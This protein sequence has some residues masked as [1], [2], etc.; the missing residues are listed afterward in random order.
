MLGKGWFPAQLG[1]LDRYYRQL[2]ERLPEAH[3]IVIGPAEDAS[4]RVTAVSEQSAPLPIRLLAFT[5]AARRE[6]RR[7]DIIDAHFALYALLPLFVGG[8]RH[9]PLL[10]H[11]HGP[12]ADENVSIGDTSRWRLRARR[13]LERIVYSRAQVVI[14]LTGAFRRV[15]VE[16]YGVSPWK[17]TVLAP[18]VDLE[19]FSAGDRSEARARFGLGPD[20]FVA[21]CAR[22]LVPRMGIDVLIEAWEEAVSRDPRARLLIAGDGALRGELERETA[23]R[24]LSDSVTLL[25]RITDEQLL[26]LYRAA[27]VN[28]VPSISFEGFGLVVLEA[29]ACGTPSIVTRAG[30]LPEAIVGLGEDLTVAAGDA[31]ALA[32]RLLRAQDGDLPSREHTRSWADTHN[33]AT[34]A[35]GH[36]EL[37][38]RVLSEREGRSRKLRVV[39][40]DHVARLSGGELALLRLVAALS[41]VEAHVI[42]A[43]EGPLVDR[44]LQAGISV[45]VLPLPERTRDLRKDSVRIGRLALRS[46]YDTIT[47]SLRLARRLR[48]LRPDVVHTNS[49]KAG[50]YGSIAA[51]MARLP[52]VWHVRDRLEPDYLPMPAVNLVRSLARYLPDV[53]VC[54]S[55]ATKR[56][57]RPN[58]RALV[59]SMVDL[60]AP[61][62]RPH[63]ARGAGPLVVG[64]VG[65]LAP[66]KGQDVF[67]RAFARAFPVGRSQAVIVGAPL[68]GADEVAYADSLSALV[69]EL[70]IASRVEFRGHRDDITQELR[71][72][73]ILVH[74]STTPEPFGQVVIEGMSAALP[75][76]ASR[77]GGPE[78]IIT[79]GVDGL[80]HPPGD[81]AEL[82][83]ILSR[84]E[85]E[86]DLRERLGEAAAR[87]A[88]DFAPE[89]IAGKM[90]HAYQLAVRAR[91]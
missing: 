54:N 41:D 66:W 68:F 15:L 36:R 24:S 78:E 32:E 53:L 27:D 40:L 75:V 3:G 16:R 26:A 87:R 55:Q 10:V 39:Y 11:F 51:R 20:A 21:C 22:R 33:W 65:R 19:R 62:S 31:G 46:T 45:E 50:I 86:P 84:L 52:V 61:D 17:T 14:T 42:L 8:L 44:L 77:G 18:G 80:L 81:V 63:S 48:R 9:K 90:M 2:L 34:V 82:A 76:V 83:E 7:A 29:A 1:G 13:R 12:W 67:L 71:R 56:S 47:Y 57:L 72:M 59:I 69:D 58:D 35:E 30:G 38:K 49:M 4:A 89:A 73:D 6:G 79:D 25:G 37:F 88:K 85:A 23:A 74:A 28:V 70:G 60:V 64:I 5:R 91:G 43:E